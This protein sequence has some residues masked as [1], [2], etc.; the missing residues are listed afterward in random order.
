M[1]EAKTHIIK[2]REALDALIKFSKDP[3]FEH[4][5]VDAETD[6][7]S[8][9]LAKLYG[10]AACF[11]D[12]R[13]FYVVFRD[14]KGNK[15]W[16]PEEEQMI[17]AWLLETSKQKKLLNHNIIYDV[18]VFERNLGVDLTPHIYSDTI[19]LKHTLNEEKPHGLKESAA[20]EF[21]DWAKDAQDELKQSVLANGGKWTSGPKGRKDMYLADTDILA[22]YAMWDVLLTYK[23]FKKYEKKL[24]EENLDKLFYEDEIMHLYRECTIPMKRSG[25]PVD[26]EYFKNLKKEIE[27]HLDI[28]EDE[29]QRDIS[30][31]I[32]DY[33]Q[34]LL[35][36]EVPV[37]NTGNFPKILADQLDIPL[38]V[39]KS[40]NKET[41]V[42]TLK[43]TLGKAAILKQIE[44]CPEHAKFYN[45]ILG[46]GPIDIDPITLYMTQKS[47]FLNSK[48]AKGRRYVFN[49]AS[50]HDLGYYFF[51]IKGYDAIG[52]TNKGQDKLDD[53][54]IQDIIDKHEDPIAKKLTDYKKLSKLLST[55]VDGILDRQIDGIVYTSLL[56]FG[57]TSGRY[58]STNPNLQNLPRVKDEEAGL[59]ELVLH[60]VNAIK[61]GFI[62][63]PKKKIVNADYSQLEPCCF[64]SMSGDPGL[65]GVFTKGED[66]YSRVAIDVFK[67]THLSANKKDP[68]FLKKVSP[69]FRNKSKVFTLAVPYGAEEARIS[70]A[71]N[72]EFSEA[73][74]VI[75][76]YLDAYPGL[77]KYMKNCNKLAMSKGIAVTN[78]GRVRHIPIAKKLFD[79]YGVDL[80]DYRWAKSK[81]L[82][83]LRR[84]FKKALNNSKNFPIQ[85]LAAH[86]VNRSAIAM[87]REFKKRNLSA[88]LRMQVHDELTVICLDHEAEEV[89]IIMKQCMENTTKISVPLVAE[90]LIANNWSEAK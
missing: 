51:S 31:D 53:K 87:M 34:Q 15:I 90:P 71:M 64:A 63:G 72:C 81:G 52:K 2:S 40:K 84:A 43:P 30:E 24:K 80:L 79:K 45:W 19:L 85:G 26:V 82:L 16:T 36:E 89:K 54:F 66:L 62:A 10:F 28:I 27:Q 69:E 50:G 1:I 75:R 33:E 49:L 25:F 70:Q 37:T 18:L 57:T 61:K 76:A 56:Q 55:Y 41:G 78:Y 44:A 7:A 3:K 22:K 58:S 73:K 32:K 14:Q 9:R 74:E 48:K 47:T 6:S 68:N 60:Y 17:A 20:L 35:N 65:I 86:I 88:T 83:D 38:P 4:F 13:A 29:I 46:N 8:E 67:M 23:L 11:N 42:I 12:L 77:K 59:S 39:S 21:G 5:V